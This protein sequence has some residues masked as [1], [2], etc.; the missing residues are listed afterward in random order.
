MANYYWVGS[1]A[2][3][4]DS[5]SWNT[6]TNWR[7]IINA[8]AGKTGATWTTP[9]HLPMGQDY[10][11]FGSVYQAANSYTPVA[12]PTYSP[13]IFGGCS[14]GV[15]AGAWPGT[16]AGGSTAEKRGTAVM[17]VSATYPFSQLGGELNTTILNEWVTQ[18][19]RLGYSAADFAVVG[20]TADGEPT[21]A[22]YT[23]LFSPIG[24]TSDLS[25]TKPTEFSGEG[26]I[27]W[28]G[29][30]QDN[31]QTPTK[32]FIRG[33]T[34]GL[35][36]GMG[37]ATYAYDGSRNVY[38][39][40]SHN[41]LSTAGTFQ[42]KSAYNG[43]IAAVPSPDGS[44]YT[45]G[46]SIITG[47]WNTISGAVS[48]KGGSIFITGCTCNN[49]ILAPKGA[50][51]YTTGNTYANWTRNGISGS[52]ITSYTEYD[53]VSFDQSSN[54]KNLQIS[55]PSQGVVKSIKTLIVEGDI[56][57]G[58]GFVCFYPD[59]VTAG[60][61]GSIGISTI[62]N[63][64]LYPTT[65]GEDG[66]NATR[67]VCSIG[68][69]SSEANFRNTNLSYMNYIY[70]F[71]GVGNEW[72]IGAKGNLTVTEAF[73]WG[74]SFYADPD[75]ANGNNVQ[76]GQLSLWG[77]A[78]LDL[79]QAPNHKGMDTNVIFNSLDARLLPNVGSTIALSSPAIEEDIGNFNL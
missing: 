67:P 24:L 29:Y 33:I 62:G 66:T 4:V 69:P 60:F 17:Y 57:S 71:N 68:Y 45:H 72:N 9:T 65:T 76:V 19:G 73:M 43:A 18:L 47:N 70:N 46:N 26:Y 36:S 11:Y 78:T 10:V 5:L 20:N 23:S 3:S 52:V 22:Y 6:V 59:G 37:G 61:T 44:L 51:Y 34:S 16:T 53:T 58:S 75:I 64:L 56:T 7:T 1:T 41:D 49:I 13:M 8:A 31:S 30:V 39:I 35:T 77:D 40:G 21:A 74:G 32:V 79:S 12:I 25:I 42:N 15:T 48:T 63:L 2:A 38:Y 54:T 55:A 14:A 27:R 28:M 50:Y